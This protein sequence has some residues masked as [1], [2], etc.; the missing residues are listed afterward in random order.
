MK[1]KVLKR[2]GFTLIEL[3]VV[4]A[5][6][7]ILAALLLPALMKAREKARQAVCMNNLKQLGLATLMYR[8][9][10]DDYF[11][12][13][14][15]GHY[16]YG[17]GSNWVW[18]LQPYLG[19]YNPKIT[20]PVSKGGDIP[21][22]YFCPTK[23]APYTQAWGTAYVFNPFITY[24]I[25]GSTDPSTWYLAVTAPSWAKG[26]SWRMKIPNAYLDKV[27]WM[28][29][30]TIGGHAGTQFANGAL[31]GYANGG[32][33][34]LHNGGNNY[35]FIDGHVEWVPKERFY[36]YDSSREKVSVTGIGWMPD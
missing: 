25:A 5:I 26:S 22:V 13:G 9:D 32:G 14:N 36:P 24:G 7:S 21:K 34:S 17:H 6:I 30:L 3:L 29:H 28:T 31:S 19:K 16:T 20:G 18:T 12:L 8:S 2:S 10:W 1:R 27:I 35:L 23:R 11:P 15:S 33:L 4:V